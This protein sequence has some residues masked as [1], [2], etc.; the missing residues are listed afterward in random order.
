MSVDKDPTP[1]LD[2]VPVDD[3]PPF[4]GFGSVNRE[5]G[6]T[7]DDPSLTDSNVATFGRIMLADINEEPE[8]CDIHTGL[9]PLVR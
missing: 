5:P 7:V 2:L 4:F 3:M 6:R 8:L 1:L 9:C